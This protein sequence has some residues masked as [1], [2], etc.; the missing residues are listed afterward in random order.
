VDAISLPNIGRDRKEKSLDRKEESQKL[1]LAL[2]NTGFC[3]DR[4]RVRKVQVG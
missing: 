3:K 2:T 4:K 1:I